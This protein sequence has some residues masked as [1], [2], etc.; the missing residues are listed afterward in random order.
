MANPANF[1]GIRARYCHFSNTKD[2]D[3]SDSETNTN[4]ANEDL[5]LCGPW[6]LIGTSS[7]ES[8]ILI[9]N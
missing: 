9:P 7:T 4:L 2:F 3:H 6:K 8:Y 1:C 5:E